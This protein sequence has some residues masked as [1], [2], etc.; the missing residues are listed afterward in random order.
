MEKDDIIKGT[1]ESIRIIN[2]AL[3]KAKIRKARAV[4]DV[5][6]LEAQHK[7]LLLLLRKRITEE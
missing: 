2:N 1:E 5:E 7:K 3:N 6:Q 4:Y